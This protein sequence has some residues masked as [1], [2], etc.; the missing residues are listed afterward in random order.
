MP[1]QYCFSSI[2]EGLQYRRYDIYHQENIFIYRDM[3]ARCIGFISYDIITVDC[4]M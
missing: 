2:H 4:Q 3:Q 1:A